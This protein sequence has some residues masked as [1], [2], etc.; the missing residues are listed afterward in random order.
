MDWSKAAWCV[1]YALDWSE[2]LSTAHLTPDGAQTS[3]P[4]GLMQ[5]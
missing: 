1:S 5:T 4:D 3:L 2:L